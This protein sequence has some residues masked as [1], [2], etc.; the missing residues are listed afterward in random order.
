MIHRC[1]RLTSP[2][3][4]CAGGSGA[5]WSEVSAF[6]SHWINFA[7]YKEFSWVDEYNPASA[8][9]RKVT[10]HSAQSSLRR[11]C[12]HASERASEPTYVVLCAVACS[13]AHTLHHHG[14]DVS[15]LSRASWDHANMLEG[16]T[17]TMVHAMQVRRLMEDENAKRRKAARR[18]YN[19]AV[20]ELAAFVRKRDK[21][22][23][24]HQVPSLP[25]HGPCRPTC[26]AGNQ[27]MLTAVRDD[28]SGQDPWS[29][30][31]YSS[32]AFL[33]LLGS[34]TRYRLLNGASGMLLEAAR[35][36]SDDI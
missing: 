14:L 25:G 28:A 19:D 16:C 6:Y 24:A 21:R 32:R 2:R 34:Q 31:V 3:A 1:S 36:F 22:V 8:P 26:K 30:H 23:I 13:D 12:M 7:T 18:N 11:T 29:L 33:M 15:Y 4:A 17:P 27:A 20:R 10:V 5:A 35:C 9:N